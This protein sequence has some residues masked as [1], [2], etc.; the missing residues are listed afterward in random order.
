MAGTP[1]IRFLQQ[2]GIA[3]TTHTYAHDPAATSFGLE[4]AAALGL[5]VEQVFKTLMC[6]VDGRPHVAIVPVHSQLNLKHLA[7]AVHGKKADMLA[8][9]AAE[10]LTGYIAGG[11]S[12]FGQKRP[13]PT[14]IDETALLFD[15]IY[16]SGGRRGFDIGI[17]PTDLVTALAAIVAPISR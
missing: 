12:P 4:A 3:H 9:T 13:S 17:S 15:T 16:V 2:A 7:S 6:E 5:P 14:V 8:V 10:R 11:I 1:A